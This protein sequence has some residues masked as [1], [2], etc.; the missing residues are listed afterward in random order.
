[1]TTK[2]TLAV[3]LAMIFSGCARRV[4]LDPEIAAA[5]NAKD[6]TIKREP[7]RP[8]AAAAPT[9]AKQPAAAPASDAQPKKL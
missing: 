5:R 7:G 6:W 8:A 1:M 4:T 9:T 3:V 2:A